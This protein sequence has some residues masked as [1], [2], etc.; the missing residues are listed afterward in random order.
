MERTWQQDEEDA[1]RY[2]EELF[3]QPFAKKKLEVAWPDD[4]REIHEFDAVSQDD[5]VVAEVK[6]LRTG[7]QQQMNDA[8]YDAYR[9]ALCRA[10]RKLLFLTDRL[11][12]ELMWR[13]KREELWSVRRSGV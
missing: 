6:R 9:L 1:R 5:T 3:G 10:E 8:I 7:Q 13:M 2:L 12:Y 11:F 4:R